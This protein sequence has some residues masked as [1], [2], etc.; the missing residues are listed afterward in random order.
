[1]ENCIYP[2]KITQKDG[3][4]NVVPCNK[5]ARCLNSRRMNWL[6]RIEMENK[7]TQL[8]NQWFLTLTYNEKKC[9]R[10]RGVRT[11]YKRHPQL[12]FKRIR[13]LGE[14]IKYILVG[15]YGGQTERPH[16]HLI[17]WT[18][19]S[20]EIIDRAWSYGYVHYRQIARESIL[21]T[22]KYILNPR[23]GDNQVKQKEY[24]VFSKGLGLAYLTTEMYDW[25]T[26]DYDNPKFFTIIGSRKIPLPRYYRMKIF[27]KYQLRQNAID[28]YYV[29]LK[30]K[31][32]AIRR[33]KE[34]GYK[35]AFK[36]YRAQ[37]IES[38]NAIHSK[39]KLSKET[40]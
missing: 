27:T 15:E 30:R 18:S 23:Q 28:M 13:K 1:M 12:F 11:L 22:L 31:M 26:R 38:G 40:L 16:Y 24:A 4:T 19:A 9:P 10:K 25:H 33:L 36:A 6:M 32:Q 37:V 17:C 8:P 14:T 34:L 21:Y 7:K 29:A 3:T 5:C 2:K 39:V 20:C 35:S